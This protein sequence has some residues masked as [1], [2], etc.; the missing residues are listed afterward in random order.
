MFSYGERVEHVICAT[1]ADTRAGEAMTYFSRLLAS[2]SV[3]N[4]AFGSA[5]V[6]SYFSYCRRLPGDL[7]ILVSDEDIL[8]IQI[9]AM[10]E[11]NI[12]FV[13]HEGPLV[14]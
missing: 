3:E 8:R 6:Q 11:P 13:H 1:S 2:L 10:S 12:E 7:D 5:A 14:V 4:I 9:A